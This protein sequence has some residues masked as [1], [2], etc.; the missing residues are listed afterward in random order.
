M[1]IST[2]PKPAIYRNLYKN[3]ENWRGG[4]RQV[5]M[6]SEH[7]PLSRYPA[8]KWDDGSILSGQYWA[9]D[10]CKFWLEVGP[11]SPFFTVFPT[12]MLI[13]FFCGHEALSHVD[14]GPGEWL[15]I[16]RSPVFWQNL[17]PDGGPALHQRRTY[18]RLQCL[19]LFLQNAWLYQT[20]TSCTPS[21]ADRRRWVNV[22]PT[23]SQRLLPALM[24]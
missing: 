23:L 24:A 17:K 20:A 12:G 13:S 9:S 14:I 18:G 6:M 11:R 1:V 21:P 4:D 10:W 2:N 16:E 8:K 7:L 22:G 19:W 5:Y 15:A 3:T